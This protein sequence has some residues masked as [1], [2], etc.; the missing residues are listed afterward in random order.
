MLELEVIPERGV[1]NGRLE[2]ILG[3]YTVIS[4][5]CVIISFC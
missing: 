3:E 4:H 1:T 2:L 5:N